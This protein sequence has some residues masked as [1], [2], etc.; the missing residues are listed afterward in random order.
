MR[1]QDLYTQTKFI[2]SKLYGRPKYSLG[3]NFLLDKK[4]LTRIAELGRIKKGENIIEIGS[5]LGWLTDQILTF[6]PKLTLIE[7]DDKFA[8]LLKQ[9]YLKQ[10]QIM[11]G[12]ILDNKIFEKL[13]ENDFK[14]IANIPYS[15]TS[16]LISRL[17]LSG[18]KPDLIVLLVQKEVAER[19]SASADN[20]ERG[21]LTVLVENYTQTELDMIVSPGSFFPSPKVDSQIL[22]LKP[23]LKNKVI[24]TTQFYLFLQSSFAQKRKK[25]S[26]IFKKSFNYTQQQVLDLF[27]RA[28]VD[29][30]LRPEDLDLSAWANLF[31]AYK[32]LT[33]L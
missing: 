12:D 27:S 1:D 16:P 8:D 6:Q 18:K 23:H 17:I 21:A 15:I 20:S 22:I 7:K 3:Q 2:I 10:C 4:I 26:N 9:K 14:I 13:P 30:N 25:L 11:H 24:D 32:D 29:P 31:K 19:M 33:S 5:G 28:E